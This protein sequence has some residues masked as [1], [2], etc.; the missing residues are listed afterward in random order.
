M[1]KKIIIAILISLTC[2]IVSAEEPIDAN[3]IVRKIDSNM[4]AKSSVTKSTMVVYT[5]RGQR[6]M[7]TQSYA[8][9]DQNSFSEYLSPPRDA[10]TKMLKLGNKLWIYEPSSDRTIQL[11]GNMLRQSVMGS[12]LSYEDFME[13]SKL[14]DLY[15]AKITGEEII[16]GHDCWIINLKT[17]VK[18]ISYPTRMLWVDKEVYLP[19][20]EERY[21]KSGKLLKTAVIN[22]VMEVKGRYYPKSITFKDVLK[23]GKGTEWIIDEIDFDVEIPKNKLSKASLRK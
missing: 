15:D 16:N 6:T 4:Y 23:K 11:S 3:S 8:E 19:M 7:T 10:G 22:E 13:E 14:S 1:I 2:M 18:K 9:G 5:R 12:D 21:A 20:K 17:K